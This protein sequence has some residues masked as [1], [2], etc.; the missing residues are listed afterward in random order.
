M[1]LL[2]GVVLG[3]SRAAVFLLCFII[4]M[5]DDVRRIEA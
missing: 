1:W 4:S 2:R 5:S 3:G